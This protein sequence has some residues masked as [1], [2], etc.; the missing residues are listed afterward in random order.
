MQKSTPLSQLP[1]TQS[2]NIT[3]DS[4]ADALLADDDNTIQEVLNQINMQGMESMS[5]QQQ[6][7]Y[8][9][10]PPP[11]QQQPT[12][13]QPQMTSMASATAN[14]PYIDQPT[15]Q[16]LPPQIDLMSAYK[17]SPYPGQQDM[18]PSLSNNN[19]IDM[20]VRMF[21]SDAKLAI[22]VF[23]AVVAVHFIPASTIIGNY[24]AIDKIPYHDIII[25]AL[26][27][28]VIVLFV[29]KFLKI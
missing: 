16:Q 21:A 26:L 2:V 8:A 4:S 27:C 9:P 29:G 23:G 5:Q 14:Y 19:T 12:L 13:P 25:K 28:V 3:Q 24:I 1:S 17:S 10:P 20:F 6:P 7:T 15:S 18:N 11:M 22:L